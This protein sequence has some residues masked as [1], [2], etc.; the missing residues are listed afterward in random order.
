MSLDSI[1]LFSSTT[2]CPFTSLETYLPVTYLETSVL[3]VPPVTSVFTLDQS[4][5]EF[6]WVLFTYNAS[7]PLI[8][9]PRTFTVIGNF[10]VCCTT[11]IPAPTVVAPSSFG[12]EF[13][14]LA[15]PVKLPPL[16]FKIPALTSTAVAP[17]IVVPASML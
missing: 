9:P 4:S 17:V 8:V 16:T 6:P 14:F 11:A 5:A 10:V 1:T 12:W 13:N 7:A 15:V 2:Y 3:N